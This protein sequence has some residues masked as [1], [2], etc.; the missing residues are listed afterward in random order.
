MKIKIL[1]STIA[2]ALAIVSANASDLPAKKSTPVAPSSNSVNWTGIYVGANA[3][4]AWNN[5]SW[6]H[7][8]GPQGGPYVNSEHFSVSPASFIGGMQLGAQYQFS[9]NVVIGIEGTYDWH[10]AKDKA[11][12]DLNAYP[13]YRVAEIGNI[14]S[15]SGKLGFAT[16][17]VLAYGK[18]G[19]A[20]TNLH[21]SNDVIATGLVLGNSKGD[22]G[23]YVLGAGIEYSINANLSAA[24]EYNYYNFNVGD[25]IQ[26]SP[27][28]GSYGALNANGDLQSHAVM[29]KLNYRFG[30]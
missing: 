9:N 11:R 19:Y 25:K 20:S 16:G 3:G 10:N 29:A 14:W 1:I 8:E 30:M 5:S 2:S 23:G 24:I 21:Y 12:T 4:Y 27:V 26:R 18:A 15:V 13:R 28:N 7:K 6:D 17:S 22:I